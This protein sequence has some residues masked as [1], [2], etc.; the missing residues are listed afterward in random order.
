MLIRTASV[1]SALF[2]MFAMGSAQA[3]Y[4]EGVHYE[5]I[6]VPV[7]TST[8]DRIEVLELFW[9]GC[10]HCYQFEPLVRQWLPNKPADVEF[11]RMPATL[12]KDWVNHARAYFVADTLGILDKTHEPLFEQIH[13]AEKPTDSED[14]LAAF[15]ATHGV[16]DQKF[17]QLFT[18][19]GVQA[20]VQQA[21]KKARAYQ[22]SGVPMMIVNGKYRVQAQK[23]VFDV[24]NY[25][26][27][28]ERAE[29]AAAAGK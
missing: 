2:F 24:V 20:R 7:S 6:L 13:R 18:S 15:F 23:D 12:R 5:R 8:D 4:R 11:V 10:P 26:V 29:M 22:V 27:G 19:F 21:D 14:A 25:L 17:R 1:L 16:S 3:E 28:L 9:Y